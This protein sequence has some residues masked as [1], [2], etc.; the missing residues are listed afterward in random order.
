M[1]RRN[2]GPHSGAGL[3]GEDGDGRRGAERLDPRSSL[4]RRAGRRHGAAEVDLRRWLGE[5]EAGGGAV[6]G[7][8]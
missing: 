4:K 2:R 5:R 3:R 6:H 1:R 7:G 8:G